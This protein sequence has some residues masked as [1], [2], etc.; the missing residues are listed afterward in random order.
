MMTFFTILLILVGANA[1]FMVFSLSGTST[2][3]KKHKERSIDA[4]TTK[5]YPLNPLASKYEK[6][7]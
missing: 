7:V 3:G 5:V 6:A 2:G 1:I 4:S